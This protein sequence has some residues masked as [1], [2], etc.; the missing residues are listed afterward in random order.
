[1]PVCIQFTRSKTENISILEEIVQLG[2]S[3]SYSC[4]SHMMTMTQRLDFYDI[5]RCVQN[6]Y[7]D[8]GTEKQCHAAYTVTK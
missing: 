8:F 5:S 7:F 1:M 3:K 2:L 4:F 6:F